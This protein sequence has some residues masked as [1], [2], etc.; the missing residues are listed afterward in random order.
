[1]TKPELQY[2]L[3]SP[4]P[5]VSYWR[6]QAILTIV[7]HGWVGLDTLPVGSHCSAETIKNLI[8]TK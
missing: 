1:L 7:W 6:V 8:S 2:R 3:L 4:L 5:C